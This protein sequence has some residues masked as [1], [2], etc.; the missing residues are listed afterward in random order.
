MTSSCGGDCVQISLLRGASLPS[1]APIPHP[2]AIEALC[3]LPRL[4]VVRLIG[5]PHTLSDRLAGDL[6]VDHCTR[7]QW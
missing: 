7:G 5:A 2:S 6:F 4:K 3:N 1:D